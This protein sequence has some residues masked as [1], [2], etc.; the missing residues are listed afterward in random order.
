MR[1]PIIKRFVLGIC[2][3]A[4]MLGGCSLGSRGFGST[5]PLPYMQSGIAL[6]SLNATGAGKITHI[7]YI[8]QENRSFNNLFY[9]YPGAYTVTEGQDSKGNTIKLKPSKLGAFYDIDHSVQAMIEA[10]NGTGTLRGTDC[11][12]NGFDKEWSTARFKHP[13]YV[14]VPHDQSKPYFDMAHE[15]ALGD[16]MFQSQLDESFV[17]HQ[18][19]IAAQ[20]AWSANLPDGLWGCE[21]HEQFTVQKITSERACHKG[22]KRRASTM[23]LLAT[24]S[25]RPSFRGA[26]TPASTVAPRAATAERGP[27]IRPLNTSTMGPIGR[28]TSF[29]RIGSSSPTSAGRQACELHLDHACLRRL[30]PHQLPG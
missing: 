18:Y 20:A 3:G 27:A 8:V 21:D 29:P 11:R 26:S 14:Y 7:V 12:M 17:A 15:G 10:C 22:V 30:R 19:V 1:V 25:T 16:R 2:A 5:Q 6:R 9:G 24:N 28:K 13:Q 4:A 23:K